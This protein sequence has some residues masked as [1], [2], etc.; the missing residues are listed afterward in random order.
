MILR[1]KKKQKQNDDLLAGKP[2]AAN[3]KPT[4]KSSLT[5]I[6]LPKE[7]EFR[8]LINKY[9]KTTK[10]IRK[11][12]D[13][14]EIKNNWHKGLQHQQLIYIPTKNLQKENEKRNNLK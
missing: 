8:R 13:D 3:E 2:P 11:I 10:K 9:Y 1:T 6:S 7:K 5:V 4:G 14:N 12:N